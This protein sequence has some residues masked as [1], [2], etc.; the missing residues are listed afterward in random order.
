MLPLYRLV[1][2]PEQSIP[3]IEV[4]PVEAG[5]YADMADV[6][7]PPPVLSTSKVGNL[8]GMKKPQNGYTRINGSHPLHIGDP[9]PPPAQPSQAPPVPSTLPLKESSTAP[10]FHSS[11][12][13]PP[14]SP[15]L[16]PPPTTPTAS[17]TGPHPSKNDMTT[18]DLQPRRSMP[19]NGLTKQVSSTYSLADLGAERSGGSNGLVDKPHCSTHTLLQNGHVLNGFRP[20]SDLNLDPSSASST[21]S[22]SDCYI[23]SDSPTPSQP[24]PQVPPPVLPPAASEAPLPSPSIMARKMGFPQAP[25]HSHQGRVNGI[26]TEMPD[27]ASFLNNRRLQN[28]HSLPN[29]AMY[30]SPSLNGTT[31]NHQL[32]RSL[33]SMESPL[34]RGLFPRLN[35]MVK[36]EMFAEALSTPATP[37]HMPATPLSM[38]Q[39][40]VKEEEMPEMKPLVSDRIH[41]IPG[42]VAMALGHGSILIECAKKELHATTSIAHPCRAMP[43]R[44]SMVFYQHKRLILR[45][46]G[47]YEEEEKAKKRQEEQ[48]RQK[49]LKMHEEMGK[50][51]TVIELNPPQNKV[52]K[53]D[54]F[55][56]RGAFLPP[57]GAHTSDMPCEENLEDCYDLSDTFDL[58]YL[59][60]DDSAEPDVVVGVVPKAIPL[61]EK[62]SPF[63]LELPVER[64]DR[65]QQQ[66]VLPSLSHLPGPSQRMNRGYVAAPTLAT[67]T[68]TTTSCK[69]L[70]MSSGN[71]TDR[72][73]K[74]C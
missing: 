21:D 37:L 44:I 50:G 40:D 23:L 6:Q 30:R 64:V 55:G 63:Y 48:Q 51:S 74:S 20:H 58:A 12:R 14:P 49:Y 4:R 54:G 36:S 1:N 16:P 5:Q 42:G 26:K 61:T 69:P 32:A 31:I 19:I 46:H 17:L 25:M 57:L 15:A 9:P 10:P 65:M 2:P 52:R 43:T 60:D 71:F 73:K 67:N 27:P 70:S 59:N 3:G 41:A 68:C 35:G 45:H 18:A 24:S 72:V 38:E 13:P 11:I 28:G 39:E 66:S 8:N 34:D 56:Q 29:P 62:E 47:W 53:L 33:S 22:D 7:A